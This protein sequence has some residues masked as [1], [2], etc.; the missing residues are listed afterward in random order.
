MFLKSLRITNNAGMIRDIRFRSGMNLVVDET[1]TQMNQATGNNVGKTT[2]LMLIE[3]CLG[4]SGKGIYTDP[5]NRKSQYSL[6]KDFLVDS[7]VLVSLT[8]KADLED[9]CSEEITIERNFLQRKQ[10]VRRINGHQKTEE[11][12]E[13]FLT[14]Q[15]FPGHFGKK[16]TFPQI[17]SHNI[18]YKDLSVVN[19]LRT[20]NEF[21]RDDE[22][23]TLYLFLLG[24]DFDRGDA[25]QALL[26]RIRLETAF[27]N[28]LESTQT[29]SAYEASLALLSA[30]IGSL[31][32]KRAA[33]HVNSDLESDLASFDEV[34][35]KINTLGAEIGRLKLRRSLISEAVDDI[36]SARAEIDTDQ[37][38]ILYAEAI[39][40]MSGV[41]RS[42]VDLL[43]F[44]NRMT[45]EKARYISKDLPVLE[46]DIAVKESLLSRLREQE[47][48]LAS[49][50][51]QSV[52]QGDFEGLIV[53]L[54]DKY[55]L[56]GEF[57]AVIKQISTAENTLDELGKS[58]DEIDSELFSPDFEATIQVQLNKFNKVFSAISQ[59]LYGE[60]YA[61][62]VDRSTNKAGQKIYKFN[63]FN[64]NFSS[65]KKQGEI[66]CF[67][68]AYT[69]FADAEG[70]SCY[71]F[72]LSDKKELMHDNQLVK[73]AALV[74]RENVHVQFVASILR[75][76]LPPDLNRED[77]FVLRL[78]P[79]DKLFRIE[80]RK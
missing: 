10:M 72:L 74:E 69:L 38:R 6:V 33:F 22:Y 80:S 42:F 62:K 51:A 18:R 34:R 25:K 16:P 70:I 11:E 27:K 58:L 24:C 44:H 65:G 50:V 55:R 47:R 13:E 64:T 29:R 49:K 36:L 7:A 68:I 19:T 1:P 61:L 8:L 20:L 14:N 30:E 77:F 46:Q 37:L 48:A 43:E 28:R 23:E 35:Y 4:G 78:S 63:S 41:H 66:T 40:R 60:K 9:P 57:E 21:T 5:E 26:A 12:F 31:N 67:D 79:N 56:L 39:E 71:H 76:K 2:V 73:I 32:E 45:D 53:A 15:L 17:T 59:E 52:S 3:F 75:D 54:N